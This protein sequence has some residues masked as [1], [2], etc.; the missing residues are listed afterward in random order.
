M[1]KEHARFQLEAAKLERSVMFQVTVFEK[2]ER[3][4]R[5]LF[6]ET[7]CYDPFNFMI[8]FIVRDA[9]TFEDVLFRF[10]EQL[11]HRGFLPIRFRVRKH[12]PD[13]GDRGWGEWLT[14]NVS[15]EE[16]ERLTT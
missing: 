12:D 3:R 14:I 6:A 13:K 16:I 10:K 8:H 7:Q 1:L 5:R 11:I 4:G 9:E 2:R 15:D